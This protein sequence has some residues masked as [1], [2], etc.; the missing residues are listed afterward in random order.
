MCTA[1]ANKSIPLSSYSTQYLP[2]ISS[3]TVYKLQSI[4]YMFYSECEV[5]W[6]AIMVVP[7]IVQLL[8]GVDVTKPMSI[9]TYARLSTNLACR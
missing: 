9:H 2:D 5:N 6:G 8:D 7:A 1:S 3:T 4:V